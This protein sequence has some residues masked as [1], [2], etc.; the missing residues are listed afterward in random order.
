MC[1]GGEVIIENEFGAVSLQKGETTLIGANCTTIELK[2][3]GAKLLEV[4]I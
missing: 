1:V 2:S 4:T 3:S